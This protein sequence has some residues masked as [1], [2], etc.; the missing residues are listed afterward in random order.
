MKERQ[1]N[2]AEVAHHRL[3]PVP[4]LVRRLAIKGLG[5]QAVEEMDSSHHCLTLVDGRHPSLLEEGASGGHH[6]LVAALHDAVLLRCVRRREVALDPLISAIR[7]ELR[8]CELTI[9]G[10]R[11]LRPHSSTVA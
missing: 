6:H 7:H 5:G 11:S 8:L 4:G 1:P 9:V 10:T 3:A 2:N